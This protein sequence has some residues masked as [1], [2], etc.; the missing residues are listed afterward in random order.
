[1][2]YTTRTIEA[3]GIWQ[4]E[5]VTWLFQTDADLSGGSVSW[6]L[7]T[8]EGGGDALL[9]KTG[10]IS[11]DEFTVTLLDTETAAIDPGKYWHEAKFTDSGGLVSQI[12][13]PSPVVIYESAI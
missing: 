8:A 2:A 7:T 3:R 1:M 4:G 10:V 9:T 11:G 6:K 5:D 12:V 13:A